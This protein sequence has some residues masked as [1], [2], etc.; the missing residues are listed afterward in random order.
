MALPLVGPRRDTKATVRPVRLKVASD[1]AV[2]GATWGSGGGRASARAARRTRC[3]PHTFRHTFAQ[4]YLVNGGDVFN[5]QQILRHATLDM[6]R[7]Y[8][9]LSE[10]DLVAR[11]RTASSADRLTGARGSRPSSTTIRPVIDPPM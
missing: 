4:G 6:V 1:P 7:R 8:V 3:S 5:L 2:D 9:T 10:A 11:H